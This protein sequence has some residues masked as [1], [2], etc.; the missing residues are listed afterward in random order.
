LATKEASSGSGSARSAGRPCSTPKK[1][2]NNRP[3]ASPWAPSR[4]RAFLHPGI[5]S[6]TAADTRGFNFRRGQTRTTRTRPRDN[7]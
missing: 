3:W 7:S 6:M 1:V 4:T 5:R 2:M